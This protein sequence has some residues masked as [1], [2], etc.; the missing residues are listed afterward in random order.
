M[1]TKS[2]NK[3]ALTAIA[4][5]AIGTAA[6]GSV[7]HAAAVFSPNP[8]PFP[9]GSGFD[10]HAPSGICVVPGAECTYNVYISN[11][12]FANETT[13]A[14][15]IQEELNATFYASFANPTTGAPAGTAT[16]SLV[17]G[18]LFT[19]NITGGFNP[20]TNTLGTFPETLVSASFEGT[21]SNGNVITASLSA[22]PSNGS[23]TLASATG[24]YDITN[25]FTINAASTVNGVP[26]TVPPLSASGI[27]APEPASL[28][29][30]AVS[31]IGTVFA[32]R[33]RRSI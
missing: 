22:T 26:I 24:G 30:L 12:Q 1:L 20:F 14:G 7:A 19:A 25:T 9:N 5:I 28:A 11:L 27:P 13:I 33:H 29:L 32:R 21:D 3:R 15:G 18:T 10:L 16:L 23:V 6:A 4:T 8:N 17:P 31:M 2:L